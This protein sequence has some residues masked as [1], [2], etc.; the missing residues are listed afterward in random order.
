VGTG[1]L[2]GG[3]NHGKLAQEPLEAEICCLSNILIVGIGI[4]EGVEPWK[5]APGATGGV[6]RPFEQYSCSGKRDSGGGGKPW[7]TVPGD[8]GGGNM[9]LEQYSCSGTRVSGGGGKS[10]KLPQE[11]PEA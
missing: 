2:E 11:P 7:K 4:L 8:T 6:N 5:T 3:R 9:P 10:W 1:I